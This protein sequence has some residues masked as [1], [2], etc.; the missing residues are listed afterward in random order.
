[1]KWFLVFFVMIVFSG[2][3]QA[4]EFDH[5]GQYT[6]DN[7]TVILTNRWVQ[8]LN[9]YFAN[10]GTQIGNTHRRHDHSY[11]IEGN[12]VSIKCWYNIANNYPMRYEG[13]IIGHFN[14][15]FTKLG[16]MNK[17]LNKVNSDKDSLPG[18][19]GF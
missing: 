8:T 9:G 2:C 12:T 10:Y 17:S 13:E 1:M 3:A 16:V 19:V 4:E 7:I 11:T 14:D 6:N 15:G 5:C 18:E